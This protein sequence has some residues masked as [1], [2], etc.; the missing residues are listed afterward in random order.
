MDI[1]GHSAVAE[2]RT[3]DVLHTGSAA[4]FRP[5]TTSFQN[6][7]HLPIPTP[8]VLPV[9]FGDTGKARW[10][11]L[12]A[13]LTFS[14]NNAK[15]IAINLWDGSSRLAEFTELEDDPGSRPVTREYDIPNSEIQIREVNT[16]IGISVAVR[17]VQGTNDPRISIISAG[18]DFAPVLGQ[19]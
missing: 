5:S 2:D 18:F 16:G 19:V 10:A 15:V 6:W 17:F 3:W 8:I 7:V 13:Y 4:T 12:S 9:P 11:A 1:H 14:T